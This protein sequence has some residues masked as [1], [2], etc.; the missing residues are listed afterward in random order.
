[1]YGIPGRSSAV[2]L[3]DRETL[4]K[5]RQLKKQLETEKQAEKERKRRELTG[6]QAQKDALRKIKPED[7]FRGETD[8]Y[9]NFDDRVRFLLS[10]PW[11]KQI[12]ARFCRAK[13]E[14]ILQA[15]TI[16][17]YK[18]DLPLVFLFFSSVFNLVN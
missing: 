11:L 17:L 10:N 16:S 2:K 18:L 5:E 9:S 4:L 13:I 14:Y 12:S 7:L 1:M 6:T 8:K 3:V 15:L